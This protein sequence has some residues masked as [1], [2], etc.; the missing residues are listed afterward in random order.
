MAQGITSSASFL[1]GDKVQDPHGER[2][3][4]VQVSG[5]HCMVSFPTGDRWCQTSDL[6]KQGPDLRERLLS[7]DFS[8]SEEYSLALQALYLRHAYKY[9]PLSGL[10][11]ARVEPM[12]HQ[13]Y[14]A[15][16]VVTKLW[17]R[18]ILADEVGLGKTIEAGLVIKE[19]RA[20]GVADRVLVV[21]PANLTEQWRSE[22][23]KKFNEEFEV[24]DGT[25]VKQ[26]S[27]GRRNPWQERDSIVC[28]LQFAVRNQA[29]ILK[30]HWDLVVFDE[31]HRVRRRMQG[32]KWQ[33]TKAYALADELKESTGGLLLLTATPMQL[34]TS[35]LFSLIELVEP[36]LYPSLVEYEARYWLLP[37]LN[38]TMKLLQR[39]ESMTEAERSRRTE[40]C[41]STLADLGV[42][43]PQKARL[44]DDSSFRDKLMDEL[45]R[46]HPMADVMVR[47]RR[48]EIKDL[49]LAK[50]EASKL[51]VEPSAD[52]I[53]AYE[54]VSDYI[55]TQY[56]LAQREK[57]TAIGF[58]MV[59]YQKMLCS[60]TAAVKASFARRVEKLKKA[61]ADSA[62]V[63]RSRA[64]PFS[65]EEARESEEPSSVIEQLE[66]LHTAGEA[67]RARHEIAALESL[68]TELASIEDSKA[69][70]LVKAIRAILAEN[71][72]EKVLVFT[73][74]IET[75]MYLVEALRSRGITVSAF[76]GSM[77]P[78]E[79]EKAV[80]DFR[81]RCSVMVSTEAG[82]EGRNL[83]FCHYLIN[84]D[85]PWNP[86]RVEQRI[87]RIDRIGQKSKRVH[88]VNLALA[89]TIEER[90]LQVLERRIRLFEQS[91][92]SLDPIL[93]D[94]EQRI[95]DIVMKGGDETD[96]E[97][98]GRSLEERVKEALEN[99]KRLS[100]FVM[101]RA[102]L[103]LDKV[104]ELLGRSSLARQTDLRTYL[105]AAID[106]Y[107]GRI[108]PH[109]EGGMVITFSDG[110]RRKLGLK[111]AQFRGFFRDQTSD[112]SDDYDF[113]GFGHPAVDALVD[114]PVS[115]GATVGQRSLP[116]EDLP[117]GLYLEVF[118]ELLGQGHRQS[119]VMIRHLCNESGVV[120]SEPVYHLPPLGGPADAPLPSW[121]ER[122][123]IESH[124]K[125][126]EVD[127]AEER[128]RFEEEHESLRTEALRRENR[129]YDYRRRRLEGE[130]EEHRRWIAEKEVGGS[131]NDRRVLPARKGLLEKAVERLRDLDH[132]HEEE[133]RRIES[134][135]PSVQARMLAVG[136]V[137][138]R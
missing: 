83:Q 101:D 33:S 107:G 69:R 30:A 103:R 105:E 56:N 14:V 86:M 7:H 25:A 5:D 110:L 125:A 26:Y 31:A 37:A 77:Q 49:K 137:M 36:G 96:F 62:P 40:E 122:A 55:R 135:K 132:E 117:R 10:S 87:G 73:Q 90:V 6:R 32:R 70:E 16:R 21:C 34:D 1:V 123:L 108:S 112:Q 126:L 133:I 75:Q 116:A 72:E 97:D 19:L 29:D 121:V 13:I 43:I 15:H 130:I 46:R 119:A 93:G 131:E 47:N 64:V 18:M 8:V 92:G 100:D 85:L 120:A 2:G 52:E 88:I 11:N 60:S 58:L 76:N 129:I 138:L 61:L 41:A 134:I 50:R 128:R 118:W 20:R 81:D 3:V 78:E 114:L 66:L 127:Y 91:V 124:Q 82:G 17:P 45:V 98:L 24:F 59:T 35:E 51:L 111:S 102:S 22:L 57:Q 39:W 94:L 71:P 68:I 106:F 65:E 42:P 67:D 89:D 9:D 95:E 136:L 12:A 115:S 4:V 79:K 113:F 38:E 84:Y 44:L 74:F 53:A 99:E 48:S 23:A 54:H 28:S 80:R 109:P 63:P 104:H 27:K